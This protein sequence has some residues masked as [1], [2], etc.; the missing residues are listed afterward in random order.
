L[1]IWL[2]TKHQN[3]SK[4]FIIASKLSTC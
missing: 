3:Y 4:H 1:Q 2:Q